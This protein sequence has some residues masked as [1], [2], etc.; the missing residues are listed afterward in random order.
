MALPWAADA[1]PPPR[2]RLREAAAN[3]ALLG[4][5]RAITRNQPDCNMSAE[6][7]VTEFLREM[8]PEGRVEAA[9]RIARTQERIYQALRELSASGGTITA[10]D[11]HRVLY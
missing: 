8:T 4:A 1:P 3:L 2:D 10:E 6:E 7:V 11:V 9:D 5:A